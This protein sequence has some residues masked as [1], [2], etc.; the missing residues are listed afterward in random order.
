MPMD[1][2]DESSSGAIS[3]RGWQPSTLSGFSRPERIT[4][5]FIRK[6]LKT[7]SEARAF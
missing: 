5:R 2:V 3:Q 1:E 6:L 4:H 7:P